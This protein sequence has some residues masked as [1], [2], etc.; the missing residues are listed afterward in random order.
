MTLFCSHSLDVRLVARNR[1]RDSSGCHPKKARGGFTLVELLVVL[2]IMALLAV[3]V[4]PVTTSVLQSMELTEAGDT[5]SNVLTQ[6][7]QL[8]ITKG[9]RVEVRFYQCTP[10]GSSS[11][12]ASYQALQSW[13]YAYN[14]T[15]GQDEG[16]PITKPI[17]FPSAIIINNGNTTLS[18]LLQSSHTLSNP[19]TSLTQ[20]LGTTINY[21]SVDFNPDGSTNLGSSA[22]SWFFTINNIH[23][24]NYIKDPTS[25]PINFVTVSIDPVNG[26]VHTFRP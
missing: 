8:A 10:P 9:E 7:R 25:T 11:T 3:A 19:T 26:A 20:V 24:K 23:D 17:L 4:L 18:N 21:S 22:P 12:V 13:V 6:A 1:R 14:T 15:T 5:V 16:T 2:A